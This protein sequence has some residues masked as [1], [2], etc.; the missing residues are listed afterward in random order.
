L[1]KCLSAWQRVH[2]PAVLTFKDG[3]FSLHARPFIIKRTYQVSMRLV[4]LLMIERM[5][6]DFGALTGALTVKSL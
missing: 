2:T 3:K 1:G 5:E 4:H 6:A